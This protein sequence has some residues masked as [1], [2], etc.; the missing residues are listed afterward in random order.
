MGIE[1]WGLGVRGAAS[2][3]AFIHPKLP[4]PVVR[5][6]DAVMMD[7][8]PID[9]CLSSACDAIVGADS[10]SG[11]NSRLAGRRA[12][13]ENRNAADLSGRRRC[14]RIALSFAVVGGTRRECLTLPDGALISRAAEGARRAAEACESLGLRATFLVP[15]AHI[16]HHVKLLHTLVSRHEIGLY[17]FDPV[18][19]A[20][21][22][23][24]RGREALTVA[25]G[26]EARW[27]C[28]A[29]GAPTAESA[30]VHGG[31]LRVPPAGSVRLAGVRFP[32]ASFLQRPTLLGRSLWLTRTAVERARAQMARETR[33]TRDTS[34]H[35]APAVLHVHCNVAE[36]DFRHL[37][38][39]A[40]AAHA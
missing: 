11:V 36:T 2:R 39:I 13:V 9:V 37:D 25:L 31:L 6:T 3:G 20:P 4:H 18:R 7:L 27:Y 12:H 21:D 40:A 17:G 23:P 8:H 35:R 28:P 10:T 16:T 30:I 5:S 32:L 19:P 22:D 34:E 26:C 1:D 14:S 29:F 15:G 33:D 38:G 24:F